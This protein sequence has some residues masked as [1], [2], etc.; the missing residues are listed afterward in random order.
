MRTYLSNPAGATRQL[1]IVT[2]TDDIWVPLYRFL[3]RQLRNTVHLVDERESAQ[4]LPALARQAE[5]WVLVSHERTLYALSELIGE[6]GGGGGAGIR[7]PG[8][9][10]LED[11]AYGAPELS[12]KAVWAE[13]LSRLNCSR[14]RLAATTACSL[15]SMTPALL[16]QRGIGYPAVI[17]PTDKDP[18]D[19]FTSLYRGKV[20][21]A[22]NAAGL[23]RIRALLAPLGARTY[24]VQEFIEGAPVSWGGCIAHGVCQGFAF[25]TI[26]KS[27]HGQRGGTSTLVRMVRPDPALQAATEEL[28]GLCRLDGLFEIE[29]IR[30]G[31]GLVHFY[32]VNP[33]PWLQ[34]ST[35]L[36]PSGS[37]LKGYLAAK[38]FDVVPERGGGGGRS[39]M[40]GSASRYL[41][42]TT[43]G[44]ASLASFLRTLRHD[45][46]LG[47][48]YTLEERLQYLADV[49]RKA[50]ATFTRP[51]AD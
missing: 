38:G 25:E 39:V 45:A 18:Q 6:P 47:S 37:V 21:V 50:L 40:W 3:S 23:E 10:R 1:A 36:Q 5:T 7:L 22:E 2:G 29:F 34:V 4:L 15:E 27:P 26:V 24:I 9:A 20:A 32:E 19:S 49:S 11:R 31:S 30:S 13:L 16:S 17:K 14:F 42:L 48:A 33:R 8:S 46:R 28:A 43:P 51:T 44:D 41:H 12:N 35:L